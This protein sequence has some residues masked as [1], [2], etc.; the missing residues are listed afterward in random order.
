MKKI[1]YFTLIA[2]FIMGS[3]S[4]AGAWTVTDA[5]PATAVQG[6]GIDNVRTSKNVTITV[7]S[8]ADA[9]AAISNHSKGDKEYGGTSQSTSIYMKALST[10]GDIDDLGTNSDSTTFVGTGWTAM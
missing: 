5:G 4:F 1:I 8:N 3:A 7:V 2:V 10:G 9:Y 6:Q